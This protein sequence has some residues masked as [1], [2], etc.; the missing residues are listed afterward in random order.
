MDYIIIPARKN[1]KGFKLKN[2]KLFKTTAI[3]LKNYSD[4]VIVSNDDPYIVDLAV[5]Y[6]FKYDNRP[7]SY[8]KIIRVF[9]M[10]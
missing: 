7:K 9:K 5:K 1:S 3:T 10:Y 6:N 4:R 2:R 8:L